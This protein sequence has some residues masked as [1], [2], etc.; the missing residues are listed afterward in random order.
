MLVIYCKMDQVTKQLL[1]GE[2][3]KLRNQIF[4]DDNLYQTMFRFYKERQNTND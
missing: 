3:L 4:L 1:V 2:L